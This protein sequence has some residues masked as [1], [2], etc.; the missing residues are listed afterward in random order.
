[1][2]AAADVLLVNQRATVGDMSLASKLTSYFMA[3]RPVIGAV[4][5]RSETAR[6]LARADAGELVSPENPQAL[7]DAIE[8]FR[9]AGPEAEGLRDARSPVRGGA[10]FGPSRCSSA[11]RTSS[12]RSAGAKLPARCAPA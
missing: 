1:M 7:A 10:S 4:A 8:R 3:A 12:R 9:V 5:E 2:L 11:T 6:E